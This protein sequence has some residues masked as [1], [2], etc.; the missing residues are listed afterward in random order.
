MI[1][2]DPG[3]AVDL[4]GQAISTSNKT[5]HIAKKLLLTTN[6]ESAFRGNAGTTKIAAWS[7]A[8]PL[9]EI[10]AIGRHHHATIN[11]VLLAALGGSL[12]R[13]ALAND[14]EPVDLPTMVPVNLR[15]TDKPLPAELGNGFA[16]VLYT[17]AV[18]PD[19]A[20]GRLKLTKQR[21]DLIKD[22]PEAVLTFGINKVIGSMEPRFARTFVDFFGSK[23]TGVTTNVP[24]PKHTRYF[25]GARLDGILGWA[26]GAGDQSL[27]T[28]IFS[29]DGHVRVGFKTDGTLVPDPHAIV[30]GFHAE[31]EDLKESFRQAPAA[32]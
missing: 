2:T 21:M 14:F 27:F 16:L 26:P 32:K 1:A 7:E 13:Y 10:R 29:Y 9:D 20:K 11:D 25:A 5:G 15:D 22:S 28:T 24:G 6:P 8:I 4:V 19:T 23:A 17:L 18:E 3:Q 31:L 30:E 12:R